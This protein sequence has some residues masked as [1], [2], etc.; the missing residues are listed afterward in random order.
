MRGITALSTRDELPDVLNG[1][2]DPCRR[3]TA[4]LHPAMQ[5]MN[6]RPDDEMPMPSLT[7]AITGGKI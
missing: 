3:D 5:D 2:Q 6:T 7:C 4:A 1:D